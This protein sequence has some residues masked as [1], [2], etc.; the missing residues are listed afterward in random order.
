MVLQMG[1]FCAV[2][3]FVLRYLWDYGFS[4]EGMT[5]DILITRALE[6]LKKGMLIGGLY[7][8]FPVWLVLEKFHRP[9]RELKVSATLE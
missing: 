7:V 3:G 2:L 1:L 4:A 9:K 6:A 5:Q 8:S